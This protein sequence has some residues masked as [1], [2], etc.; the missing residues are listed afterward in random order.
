MRHVAYFDTNVYDHIDKGQVRA[1]EVQ[2][3]RAALARGAVVAHLSLVDVEE[4]LGQ[5]DT[6]HRPDAVR[7]LCVARDLVGF[8]GILKSPA[9][10]LTEAIRAYAAGMPMLPPTLPRPMRQL[11]KRE[12]TRVAEGST[13]LADEVSL[14]V[15]A[16]RAKKAKFLRGMTPAAPDARQEARDWAPTFPRLWERAALATAEALAGRCGLA[17]ACRDRGLTGLLALRI[18][19]LSVG[20]MLSLAFSHVEGGP[21]DRNDS[22]DLWHAVMASVADVFVTFDQRFATHLAR[23]PVEGFRVVTSLRAL[24]D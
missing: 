16:V 5:W 6:P 18:I 9:D 17:G 21:P 3:V 19:G 8:D 23:V 24:L 22:Y 1:E 2:A 12:L 10:L 7:R 11:V 15:A 20:M 4:L 13:H 14:L